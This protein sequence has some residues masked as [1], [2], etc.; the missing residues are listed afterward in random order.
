MVKRCQRSRCV[1]AI[2]K[3]FPDLSNSPAPVVKLHQGIDWPVSCQSNLTRPWW[4]TLPAFCWPLAGQVPL[5]YHMQTKKARHFKKGSVTFCV[6]VQFYTHYSYALCMVKRCQRSRCVGA[7]W[8]G[9]FELPH[10]NN[11]K[12]R[13]FKKKGLWLFVLRCSFT[14]IIHLHFAW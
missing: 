3:L 11:K 4:Q 8:S 7:C 12:A 10:A 6:E 2:F 14:P 13:H 1:G 5:I 9:A